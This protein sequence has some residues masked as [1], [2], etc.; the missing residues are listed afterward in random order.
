VSRDCE[1]TILLPVAV[2]LRHLKTTE[3]SY[4]FLVQETRCITMT[5]YGDPNGYSAMA[6]T[7]GLS[8][9]IATKFVMD[10]RRFL[11]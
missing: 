5:N 4:C 3:E 6:R 8:L 11:Q 7:V 9:A 10:G 2:L 1:R